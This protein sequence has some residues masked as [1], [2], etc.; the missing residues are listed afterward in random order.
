LQKTCVE[1]LV[2]A[3]EEAGV[4][5]VFGLPGGET[6]PLLEAI[7]KSRLRFVLTAHES[8]AGFMAD[9]AGR[10]TG[11]PGVCFSTLGPGATNLATGVGNA[12]LDRSPVIAI[13]GQVKTAW[14]GRTVQM[15]VC[16][17]PSSSLCCST[18]T[19]A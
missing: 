10:M 7:R 19:S 12:Y 17:C 5:Y 4:R 11:L 9:V 14:T 18:V 1:K 3:L 15:H 6:L 16:G 13:T 2:E 8:A